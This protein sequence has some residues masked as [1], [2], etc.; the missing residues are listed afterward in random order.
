M[1][2]DE[3]Q[4]LLVEAPDVDPSELRAAIKWRIKD[5][6]NFHLDDAVIDV[7]EVPDQK[8]QTSGR[9]MYA[10]AARA[11]RVRDRVD[12]A[13]DAGL[14]LDVIDIPEMALRN[15]AGLLDGDVRGV[16]SLFLGPNQGLIVITRQ[17]TLYLARTVKV[18]EDQ[19]AAASEDE[20]PLLMESI[21]LELQRSMDYYDSHFDQPGLGSVALMPTAVEMPYLLE[22]LQ[23]SLDVPTQPVDLSELMDVDVDLDAGHQAR[24]LLAI[25][26]ALRREELTL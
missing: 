1:Q 14:A 11:P 22:H 12:G 19:L 6:I 4:L 26:A 23:S 21:S 10:V 7:F 5:L 17:G 20:R 18:G 16:A 25:G 8:R 3:Y 9:L 2:P 24:A 13:N 15:V